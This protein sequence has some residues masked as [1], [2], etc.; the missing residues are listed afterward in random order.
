MPT[1]TIRDELLKNFPRSCD[2]L[3]WIPVLETFGSGVQPQ[4][5]A[6]PVED[7]GAGG[8]GFIALAAVEQYARNKLLAK[9]TCERLRTAAIHLHISTLTEQAF[10]GGQGHFMTLLADEKPELVEWLNSKHI[11]RSI[12]RVE[13]RNIVAKRVL[14][15]LYEIRDQQQRKRKSGA[16][17][18]NKQ[19]IFNGPR[20]LRLELDKS[21]VDE[22]RNLLPPASRTDPILVRQKIPTVVRDYLRRGVLMSFGVSEKSDVDTH[23][24]RV[25]RLYDES[26]STARKQKL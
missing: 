21:I 17:T 11:N 16:P 14:A 3:S 20:I 4:N 6:A 26:V 1:K 7:L 24:K 13:Y 10:F 23:S 5:E 12:R 15:I 2:F 9:G 25:Q 18:V 8:L 19:S 22:S